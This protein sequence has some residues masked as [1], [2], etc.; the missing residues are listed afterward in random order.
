MDSIDTA[1]FSELIGIIYDTALDPKVW[2]YALEQC[3]RFVG[4]DTGFL[5]SEDAIAEK[6]FAHYQS[7][8]IPGFLESYYSLYVHLNPILVP[9]LV[10]AKV[11]DVFSTSSFM[12]NQEFLESR[13][14][15]EW[16]GPHGFIDTIGVVLDKTARSFTVLSMLRSI[17]Q[18]F[19]GDDVRE[20]ARLLVPHARRSLAIGRQVDLSRFEASSLADVFDSLTTAVIMVDENLQIHFSNESAGALLEQGRL[21]RSVEGALVA[22]AGQTMVALRE[23]IAASA[24][25]NA[26]VGALNLSIALG[27]PNTGDPQIAHILPLTSGKR[28]NAGLGYNS[29]AAIFVKPVLPEVT[30]PLQALGNMYGLTSRELSVMLAIVNTGGVPKVAE[31][32]GLSQETVKSNLKRVFAKTSSSRQADLAKIVAGVANPFAVPKQ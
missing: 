4:A 14:Y 22:T 11:G 3:T 25:G 15:K 32:L 6:S 26:A 7:R 24:R 21:L 16:S 31:M 27:G 13:F 5:I 12:T 2:P 8:E 28:R 9:T 17:D 23:A 30:T 1:E 29:V 18:G 20:K 19:A 10:E